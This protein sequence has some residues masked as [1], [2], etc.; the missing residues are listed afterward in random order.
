MSNA[1]KITLRILGFRKK[2]PAE[3]ICE[4]ILDSRQVTGY[5]SDTL[6]DVEL[7][8]PDH[9]LTEHPGVCSPLPIHIINQGGFVRK[10]V[11]YQTLDAV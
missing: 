2:I 10:Y 9:L 3:M 6:I 5:R 7:P 11:K 4:M 8:Q 1:A